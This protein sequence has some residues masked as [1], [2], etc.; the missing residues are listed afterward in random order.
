MKALN[1]GS[2][3]YIIK[4][5]I[6]CDIDPLCNPNVIYLNAEEHF[7]YQDNYFDYIYSCHLI[8]HLSYN[9]FKNYL[10]ETYRCLKPGGI[11]RICFPSLNKIKEMLN[12]HQKY[13]DYF[14]KVIDDFD[15]YLYNDFNFEEYIP[16]DICITKLYR[17]WG[18]YV[19]N[20]IIKILNYVNLILVIIKYLKI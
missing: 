11:H 14:I 5:F 10:S 15:K 1:I 20:I 17:N 3:K 18:S 16:Y 2:N 13:K 9:G 6:N 19:K 7:N 12:D 8:E 4:G